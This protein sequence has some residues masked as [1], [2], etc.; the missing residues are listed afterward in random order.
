[1]GRPSPPPIRCEK[2][3]ECRFQRRAVILMSSSD[4]DFVAIAV[5]AGGVAAGPLANSFLLAFAMGASARQYDQSGRHCARRQQL[6]L[7]ES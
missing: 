2:R 1:M 5:D 6:R 4:T 3:D 7:P